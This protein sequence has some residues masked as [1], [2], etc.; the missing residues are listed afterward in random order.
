L[1]GMSKR[2][3]VVRAYRCQMGSCRMGS[4]RMGTHVRTTAA[5]VVLIAG[6]AGLTGCSHMTTGTATMRPQ[7]VPE[8]RRTAAPTVPR[9]TTAR[10]TTPRTSSDVPAPSNS[11]TMSCK[12]YLELDQNTRRAVIDKILEQHGG[13]LGGDESDITKTLAD[14]VCQFLPTSTVSEILVGGPVP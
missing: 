13:G 6:I 4:C 1:V 8:T 3:D 7:P 10:P 14:A 9:T 5:A 12:D 11:L 2:Y